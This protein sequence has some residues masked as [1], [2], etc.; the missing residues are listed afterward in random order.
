MASNKSQPPDPLER[1]VDTALLVRRALWGSLFQKFLTTFVVLGAGLVAGKNLWENVV[2]RV[3]DEATGDEPDYASFA[4]AVGLAMIVAG[5]LGHLLI[6]LD[7]RLLAKK[8]KRGKLAA[9][10]VGSL[11]ALIAMFEDQTEERDGEDRSRGQ[12][13]SQHH[14]PV[15]G[16]HGQQQ[17]VGPL[18]PLLGPDAHGDG[19]NESQH[20]EGYP[21]IELIEIGQVV[22]P[23]LVLP[24][25][26]ERAERHK[27]PQENVTGRAG[28]I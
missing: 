2:L 21:G 28:E 4:Q 22:I 11:G 24:E 25:S 27:D 20:D 19:R 14:V 6:F 5:F 17:F 7:E 26:G 18:P 13:F 23:E 3:I 9:E 8:R 12:V 1:V 15:A 10:L 16:R